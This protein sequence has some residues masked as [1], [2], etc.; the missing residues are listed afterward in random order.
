MS[1]PPPQSVFSS[2]IQFI[3]PWRSYQARILGE[4]DTHL[5]DEKLHVFAPPGSGKTI[6]G[7]EVMR[8]LGRPTLILSP[9]LAIRNQWR[10]RFVELFNAKGQVDVSFDLEIP[11]AVTTITYQNLFAAYKAREGRSP[12]AWLASLAFDTI[13]L[14]EAHHLRRE[15]WKVLTALAEAL[16]KAHLVSLTATPP[17]DVSEYEWKRYAELCGEI[18]IEIPVPELVQNGDLCP[19]MDFIRFSPPDPESLRRVREHHEQVDRWIDQACADPDLVEVVLQ[20]P[21]MTAPEKNADAIFKDTKRFV[22]LLVF[23]KENDQKVPKSALDLLDARNDELPE[24]DRDWMEAL[25]QELLYG[26][27][28]PTEEASAKVVSLEKQ[29][30][31][32]GALSRKRVQ[33]SNPEKL[34]KSIVRS[35]AKLD[36]I[37][38]VAAFEA[39]NR[40]DE[41][42]LVV[43]SDLIH[44]AEL[45]K[46]TSGLPSAPKLGVVPIFERLRIDGFRKI[47]VLTGSLLILPRELENE[48]RELVSQRLGTYNGTGKPHPS[49]ERFQLYETNDQTRSH[50]VH[51]LTR[52]LESGRIHV[53]VGTQSLLGEGWD[54]P[55]VNCLIIASNTGS[56]MLSNQI[57][58]RAIRIDN[59][60]TAKTA[61]IWH[62]ATVTCLPGDEPDLDIINRRFATF[63]GPHLEQKVLES[64]TQR[65]GVPESF[66]TLQQINALNEK[67]FERAADPAWGAEQWNGRVGKAA[68]FGP[69]ML[70]QTLLPRLKLKRYAW[71]S[72]TVE[73]LFWAASFTFISTFANISQQ[74]SRSPERAKTILIVALAIASLASLPKLLKAA[75]M[76]LKFGFTQ[77]LILQSADTLLD[78]LVRCGKL[79]SPRSAFE[80][81]RS[82]IA[83]SFSVSIRGGT[84]MDKNR[85]ANALSEMFGPVENPRYLLVVRSSIL[86]MLKTSQ[87]YLPVPSSLGDKKDH[88]QTLA[89]S[90]NKSIGNVRLIYTRNPEGRRALLKARKHS[91]FANLTNTRPTMSRWE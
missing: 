83:G 78:S 69:E 15:W 54:A 60:N 40:G 27:P 36:S 84:R 71:I 89:R 29:L 79:D 41:L 49:S 1:R 34:N 37:A 51:A 48:F 85:F 18:D 43:L 6:L 59:A 75:R 67:Q 38:K 17:Y 5:N 33:L 65:L 88:A 4:L 9:T 8:R 45:G 77:P 11:S 30:R 20:H 24:M 14:D 31:A 82:D 70:K 55:A 44:A 73:A 86:R 64:G 56:F 53:L 80:I 57:R 21:W 10:D 74:L 76:W 2:E 23:L 52:L 50:T 7:L 12:A 91:L 28:A 62:L 39:E 66:A 46:A 16:P 61:N 13:I 22:S 47:A 42:R 35:A 87:T 19:H 90:L 58:G 26:E 72:G 68:K 32:L 25:C 63:V 3:Y 81:I